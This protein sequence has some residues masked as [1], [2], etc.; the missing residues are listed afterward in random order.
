MIPSTISL[1]K[2]DAINYEELSNLNIKY[3]SFD[4]LSIPD[5]NDVEK[6]LK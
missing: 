5:E 4:F 6:S 1:M 2:S 3:P